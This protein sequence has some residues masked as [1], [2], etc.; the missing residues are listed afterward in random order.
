MCESALI[1][2]YDCLYPDE[3]TNVV[4]R[5]ASEKEKVAKR[6]QQRHTKFQRF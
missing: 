5:H 1:N 3:L 2:L 6:I 4:N